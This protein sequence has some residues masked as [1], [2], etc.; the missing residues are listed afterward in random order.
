MRTLSPDHGPYQPTQD[1]DPGQAYQVMV[2]D[3]C[4]G[5]GWGF[6]FSGV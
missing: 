6:I 5:K 2:P 4:E 1:H 3:D